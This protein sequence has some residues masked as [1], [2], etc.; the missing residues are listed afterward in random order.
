AG[1]LSS[2]ETRLFVP[3][4][5]L[6]PGSGMEPALPT[7]RP[8]LGIGTKSLAW[9][10]WF[11]S[12]AGTLLAG[13]LLAGTLLAGTLLA[14]TLL[15]LTRPPGHALRPDAKSRS[16]HRPQLC[17]DHWWRCRPGRE[18]QPDACRD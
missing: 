1:T 11:R 14:A 16:M 10:L 2:V 12:F 13:T 4:S 18:C 5:I 15:A 3:S 8:R 6:A 17:R 9:N 7:L